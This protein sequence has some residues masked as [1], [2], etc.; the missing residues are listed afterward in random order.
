MDRGAAPAAPSLFPS[1]V[2]LHQAERLPERA[3][4][5]GA[6][7]QLPEHAGQ[8][9]R[10]VP[11]ESAGHGVLEGRVLGAQAL[12]QFLPGGLVDRAVLPAV[13]PVRRGVRVLA[14]ERAVG[15]VQRSL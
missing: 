11:A 6:V 9:H 2:H 15:K 4:V 1:S 12:E 3:E 10:V 13:L 7:G 14:A 5:P 8:V